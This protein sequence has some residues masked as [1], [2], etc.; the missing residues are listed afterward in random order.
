MNYDYMNNQ[1]A[2][3][4]NQYFIPYCRY[5]NIIDDKVRLYYYFIS[6]HGSITRIIHN[7]LKRNCPEPE[8]QI[9]GIIIECIPEKLR[10][11]ALEGNYAEQI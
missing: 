9:A 11:P 8:E 2:H 1:L 5:N 6:V 7:W 4:F 3:S 10:E